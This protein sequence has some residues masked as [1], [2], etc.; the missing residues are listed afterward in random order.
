MELCDIG[1]IPSQFNEAGLR[2][3]F[4]SGIKKKIKEFKKEDITTYNA[5]KKKI[6]E[7]YKSDGDLWLVTLISEIEHEDFNTSPLHLPIPPHP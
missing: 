6:I 4:I 1:Q 2:L 7:N 5:L 3:D